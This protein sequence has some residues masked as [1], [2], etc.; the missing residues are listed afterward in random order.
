MPI[1]M[2]I[3]R[4]LSGF[5]ST[6]AALLPIIGELRLFLLKKKKPRAGCQIPGLVMLYK[7]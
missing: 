3:F 1:E 2:V 5:V 6:L 4:G 7:F